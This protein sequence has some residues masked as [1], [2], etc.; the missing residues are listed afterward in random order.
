MTESNKLRAVGSPPTE[1]PPWDRPHLRSVLGSTDEKKSDKIEARISPS[2]DRAISKLL[3]QRILPEI[4][5]RTDIV[6][7]GIGLLLHY[8][9]IH[10]KDSPDFKKAIE[11]SEWDAEI[12]A[13]EHYEQRITR[14][15]DSIEKKL[16]EA[17]SRDQKVKFKKV[18]S[19]LEAHK[20]LIE[21]EQLTTRAK[22]IW[23][24]YRDYAK[25]VEG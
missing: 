12:A 11:F 23:V 4:E 14:M 21:D 3:S 2:R 1:V 19:S 6:N 17:K 24:L 8:A 13:I 5:N 25:E 22:K 7:A 16:A 18:Y 20:D 15:L 10:G 9:K